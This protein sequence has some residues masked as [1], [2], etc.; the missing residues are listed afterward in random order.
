MA[1]ANTHCFSGFTGFQNIA[2]YLHVY[3]LFADSQRS[4]L[5]GYED[6]LSP[7]ICLDFG[8]VTKVPTDTKM[9]GNTI[10]P[11]QICD[12]MPF[13]NSISAAMLDAF[14][15]RQLS[16]S[17][18]LILSSIGLGTFWNRHLFSHFVWLVFLHNCCIWCTTDPLEQIRSL[19]SKRI[20]NYL[21][22]DMGPID[23]FLFNFPASWVVP[24]VKR[25]PVWA[26]EC[27][28]GKVSPHCRPCLKDL[29]AMSLST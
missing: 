15:V 1:E 20:L 22:F 25:A 3:H 23:Q 28:C 14:P 5:K 10:F 8:N 21:I 2:L 27:E 17:A 12:A 16:F 24:S 9:L 6:R 19:I 26:D 29:H 13:Q 4:S 18:I 7:N 11:K